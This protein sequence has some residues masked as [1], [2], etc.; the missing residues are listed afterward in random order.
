M[1][2]DLEKLTLAYHTKDGV[3]R[4]EF[5]SIDEAEE[6]IIHWMRHIAH[7]RA[8]PK[9]DAMHCPRCDDQCLLQVVMRGKLQLNI[10]A[11]RLTITD[12]AP[13]GWGSDD[14]PRTVDIHAEV[15]P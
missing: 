6:H 10:E 3:Q 11:T 2:E 15:Q 4:I 12:R 1:S 13:Q 5:P 7:L 8:H 14:P 9:V